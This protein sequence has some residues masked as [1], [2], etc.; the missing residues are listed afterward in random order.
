VSVKAVH[1]SAL[2][3]NVANVKSHDFC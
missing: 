2:R 3:P 1:V